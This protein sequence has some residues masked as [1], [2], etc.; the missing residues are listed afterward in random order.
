MRINRTDK[1]NLPFT[2]WM[3]NRVVL[4][5][6]EKISDHGTSFA[7]ATS[8]VMSLGVRPLAIFA[9]PGVERE[10][11]EYASVNSISS[12]LVKFGLVE[13]VALP[14]ENAVKRIDEN[15]SKY[16]KKET[17]SALNPLKKQISDAQS[18]RFGTQIMKLGAGVL[19]A[20]PK[21]VLTVALIPV[22]MDNLFPEKR[23][24]SETKT[25]EDDY[26]TAFSGRD[27]SKVPFTGYAGE[28]LS[29]GLGKIL[30][31]SYFQKFIKKYQNDEKNIAKHMTAATDIL[32]TGTNALLI[33]KSSKIKDNRKN[34]LIFNSIISTA[35]TLGC[36]YFVDRIIKNNTNKFVERF[37]QVNKAN[38]KLSKYIQ[39]INILRPALIFAGI[40]YGLLP[41]I[42]TYTAERFDKKLLKF[43]NKS[44]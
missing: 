10:N 43:Q 20:I 7:A 12:G 36:G 30:D 4:K 27:K 42:S 3:N 28:K 25:Y 17:I 23:K 31:N 24:L 14:V 26:K 5:G 33:K 9:T 15:P 39:G 16:L 19:S 13:A 11:K 2:S 29:G 41:V 32:L 35:I 38:P 1:N 6:L 37:S 8:L 22:I 18:Y 44:V 34:P 40:Y 21:S